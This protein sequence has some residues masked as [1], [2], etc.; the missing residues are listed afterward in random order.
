MR[1]LLIRPIQDSEDTAKKLAKN[2]AS[3]T[4]DSLINIEIETGPTS[5]LTEFQ[6]IIFTSA[7][8]VRAFQKTYEEYSL[9]AFAVGDKTAAEAQ[10]IGFKDIISA[11]GNMQK[12]SNTIIESL[13][14]NNGAL[15]YLCGDHVAG[16]LK[17]GLEDAGFNIR[18][19]VLYRAVAASNLKEETKNMLKSGA[20]DFIPFYSPRSALIFIKLI[21]DAGLTNSLRKTSALCLSPAIEKV[22]A[23]L[24]WKKTM[25]AEKPTQSDL[26]KMIDIEL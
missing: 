15:L 25:T 23:Q 22:V 26:F 19:E 7:S 18:K 11:N 17:S 4:I 6:A 16:S 3:T 2:G 24:N 9:P 12:L 14:P 21:K 10:A 1:F 8:A 5:D 13:S 20:I